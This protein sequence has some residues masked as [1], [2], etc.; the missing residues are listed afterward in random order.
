MARKANQME[1]DWKA[2]EFINSVSLSTKRIMYGQ[3]H[4]ECHGLNMRVYLPGGLVVM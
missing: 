4:S 2:L 1:F 3:S